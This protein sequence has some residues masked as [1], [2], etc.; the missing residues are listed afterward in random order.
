MRR[1]QDDPGEPIPAKELALEVRV[2]R[3][4]IVF[5]RPFELVVVRTWDKGFEPEPWDAGKLAPLTV[6]VLDETRRE[7]ASHVQ[8]T[9]TYECFTFALDELALPGL[10]LRATSREDGSQRV[11]LSDEHLLP[12]R[13]TLP[14]GD[15]GGMEL[16]RDVFP[17]PFPWTAGLS[18]VGLLALLAVLGFR[19]RARRVVAEPVVPAPPPH[20]LA[21][22]RI[23]ALRSRAAVTR[24]EV[25]AFHVETT[26]IVRT[27][28]ETRF[29]LHAP[30]KT[31]DEFFA[32]PA[33][34][35]A[36]G[37]EERA[38]LAALLAESDLV[39]YAGAASGEAERE[40]LLDT[41]EAFV[42]ATRPRHDQ[43]ESKRE[44]AA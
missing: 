15:E 38:R 22:S 37:E 13:T 6:R 31:T 27:Y 10:F 40:G 8:T 7:N 28:I 35:A 34:A 5:G 20:V 2:P 33:T 43:V 12:V 1:A 41:L 42:E 44:G 39:K 30:G 14:E 11:A 4:E 23:A 16:P 3:G 21:A 25:R 18:G 29:E 36:L 24:E 26:A 9:H 32:D 17:A 19:A